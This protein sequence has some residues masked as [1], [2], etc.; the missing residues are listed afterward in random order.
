MSDRELADLTDDESIVRTSM[1]RFAVLSLAALIT[2]GAAIQFSSGHVARTEAVRDARMRS[3]GVAT[4]LVS[5]LVDAQLRRGDSAAIAR[6]TQAMKTRIHDGTFGHALVWDQ[7]GRVLWSDVTPAIGRRF[8]LSPELESAFGSAGVFS[9]LPQD[10]DR[11]PDR[12]PGEGEMVEVYVAARGAD[13]VPYLFETL[14]PPDRIAAERAQILREFLPLGLGGLLAFQ[15]ATLPLAYS[16]ARRVDRARSRRSAV[17]QRSLLSWHQERRRLAHELHDGVVQDLSAASYA[18]PSV[19]GM[20]PPG[21]SSDAARSTADHIGVILRQ[22]LKAMRSLVSEL[23]PTDLEGVGLRSNL[24]SLVARRKDKRSVVHLE[25]A[26]DLEIGAE[27]GGVVYR[28]VRE[29]LI[30]VD[31][32]AHADNVWVRVRRIGALVDIELSDDGR[33]LGPMDQDLNEHFGLRLLEALTGD[34]GGTLTLSD[35]PEGGAVMQV[36]LPAELRG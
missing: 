35:R 30:N 23:L 9:A 19:A 5:P 32:H 17:L 28:V 1:M 4:G 22:D 8:D 14:I 15:L 18:L 36:Q 16:L 7:E 33:G 25:V 12:I 24:E 10:S 26:P 2:L 3:Q 27:V 31:R 6:L 11:H 29:G 13:G 20:L 21:P 34:V